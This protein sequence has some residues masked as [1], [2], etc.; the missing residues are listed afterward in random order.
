V[1]TFLSAQEVII[2]REAHRASR[3]KKHA[4]RIKTI[5]LL[6]IGYSYSEVA[7]VLFLDDTTTRTYFSEYQ[8]GGLDELV[9]DKYEGRLSFLKLDEQKELVLYLDE[10]LQHT[11]KEIVNFVK[12][13]FKVSYSVEGMTNL[14]HKLGFTYKKT[15]IVPGKADLQ[16]QKVFIKWYKN[17]KKTK[18]ETDV[19]LFLDGTH[20]THNTRS[21]Y[22]WILKGKEKYVKTNTGRERLNLN[23]A[24][25]LKTKDVTI[26]SEESINSLA[27]INMFWKLE[28]EYSKGNIYCICDNATYYKNMDVTSYLKTSRIKLKFLPPYSPNLNPIERLWHLFHKKILYNHY[29][30]TFKEFRENT[31][32]FFQNIKNYKKELD[33]FVTDNF[34]LVPT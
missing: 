26:F 21:A 30:P 32:N 17:L 19:I 2:L 23:G 29:Y 27:I 31:L 15:K 13:K 1:K 3:S 4:D 22:G 25:N 6:N 33:T 34:H 24:L 5:L 28:K 16:K 11:I 12:L 8:K 7:K 18:K 20:P 10:N 9:E 14:L